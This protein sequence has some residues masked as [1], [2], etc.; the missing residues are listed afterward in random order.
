MMLVTALVLSTSLSIV[1]VTVSLVFTCLQN[2]PGIIVDLFNSKAPLVM[3]IFIGTGALL[4]GKYVACCTF[5]YYI[6]ISLFTEQLYFL[7]KVKLPLYTNRYVDTTELEFDAN[8]PMPNVN[9]L[10]F[11]QYNTCQLIS[12]THKAQ[13]RFTCLS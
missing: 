8:M 5:P 10:I 3:G 4:V 7:K 9:I 2:C 11:I 12:I 1:C 13:L 6:S